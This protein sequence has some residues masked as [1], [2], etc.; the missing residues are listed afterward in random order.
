MQPRFPMGNL[1]IHIVWRQMIAG[2]DDICLNI[3]FLEG[4]VNWGVIFCGGRVTVVCVG[5]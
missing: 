1:P 2:N 5:E 3:L 4:K